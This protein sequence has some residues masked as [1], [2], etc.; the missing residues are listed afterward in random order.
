GPEQGVADGIGLGSGEGAHRVHEPPA[1]PGE[2]RTGRRDRKLPRGERAESILVDAP[3]ELGTSTR[4]TDPTTRRIDEHP[5]ERTAEGG[6]GRVLD[7]DP[8]SEPQ[9]SGRAGDESDTVR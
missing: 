1:R 4:R 7:D 2:I 3:E 8:R 9:A 6:G 5:V